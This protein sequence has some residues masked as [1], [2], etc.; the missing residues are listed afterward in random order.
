MAKQYHLGV[1]ER[2][3]NALFSGL[4][5]LGVGARYRH[6]LTVR[7]RR[8]GTPH[9]TPVDV[10]DVGGARWLVAPYGVVGWVRNAR[11]AGRVELMRGRK[12][13]QF[14]VEEVGAEQAVPVIREYIREVPV[15]RSYWECNPDATDAELAAQVPTH[16]VFRLTS[17][18]A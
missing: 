9:S 4:T 2:S 12:R 16:P 6:I 18:P 1:T 10:M 7:G 5:R 13:E 3:A 17:V 15:T 11:V 8:T 14:G